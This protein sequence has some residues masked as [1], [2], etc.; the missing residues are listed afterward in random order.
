MLPTD[1]LIHLATQWLAARGVAFDHLEPLAGDVSARR[2][3]RVTLP[4]GRTAVLAHYPP[5][6]V[7]TGERYRRTTAILES[8][9]VRVP[10]IRRWDADAGMM[11][12]EDIGDRSLYDA[13]RSGG[14]VDPHR[15]R[16]VTLAGR[17]AA[18]APAA[19]AAIN[20]R[21]DGATLRSELEQ[22]WHLVLL[23]NGLT[24]EGKL[25]QDLGLALDALCAS[26]GEAP[27]VPCHRDFMARNLLLGA[28]DELTVIDHQDLRLGPPWYDLA[29]LLNDSLY[30][31]PEQEVELLDLA[32]VPPQERQG[33]HR[34]AAQRTLK[35]IGTFTAFARRGA[36]RH[37]QLV[38]PSLRAARRHL[39]LLSET[40]DVLRRLS[41]AWDRA[42]AATAELA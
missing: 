33:Y 21:L 3:A 9:G 4:S 40:G 35:I 39:S 20:P 2:Y 28:A 42:L 37:L 15:R 36:P 16:A 25:R 11:W 24:G 7:E 34:A 17:I 27:P 18:L 6:L 19:V 5:S 29:S 1:D 10:A 23:P 26:L 14:M 31:T 32:R 8:A 38:P 12:L 13:A 22:S 41:A 30:V